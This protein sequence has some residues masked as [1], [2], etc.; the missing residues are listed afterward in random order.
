MNG[1]LLQFDL[2]GVQ[3]SI[4]HYSL[5]IAMVGSAFLIFLHLR[6]KGRLDMDEEPKLQMLKDE[7]SLNERKE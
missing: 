2:L 4:L 7:E 6:R 5:I 3:G 1:F